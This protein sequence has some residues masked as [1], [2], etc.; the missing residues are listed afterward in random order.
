MADTESLLATLISSGWHVTRREC[1]GA[2][3]PDHVKRRYSRLP[4]DVEQ[5]LGSLEVCSNRN[6]SVW[7]LTHHDY[8][9]NREEHFRWN[10]HELICLDAAG[11]DV[12][13]MERIRAFWDRH[14]PFMFAVHSDYDYLAVDLHPEVYGQ[15]VHGYMPEPEQPSPVAGSFSEFVLMFLETLRSNEKFPLTLFI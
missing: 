10:E 12:E 9:Q 11:G 13:Q 14:F 4:P 15:I 6:E 8:T 3:L 1:S 2:L 7:F 5:F